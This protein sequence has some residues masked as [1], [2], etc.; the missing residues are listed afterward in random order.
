MALC[1]FV[2]VE[3]DCRGGHG[4]F[5][6]WLHQPYEVRNISMML[7]SVLGWSWCSM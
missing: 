5:R 6:D 3:H 4:E 2:C 1:Y 7:A